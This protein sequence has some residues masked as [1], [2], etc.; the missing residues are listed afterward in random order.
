MHCNAVS[1]LFQD[2]PSLLRSVLSGPQWIFDAHFAL[3]LST[4]D[5][6]LIESFRLVEI[7]PLLPPLFSNKFF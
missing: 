2:T 5:W 1:I 6:Q 4:V 3:V 7:Q